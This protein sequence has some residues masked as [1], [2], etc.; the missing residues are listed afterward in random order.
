ML[1]H[2]KHL[3]PRGQHSAEVVAL[4]VEV[5]EKHCHCKVR[6][7]D[8]T[9]G[10]PG[11]AIKA[12]ED[13]G[14]RRAVASRNQRGQMRGDQYS[15]VGQ[16][17]EKGKQKRLYVDRVVD[18]ALRCFFEIDALRK[19]CISR[20][21]S[22]IATNLH[23][24]AVRYKPPGAVSPQVRVCVCECVCARVCVCDSDK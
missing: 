12:I 6:T 21:I 9:N 23:N 7:G 24:T 3:Q 11:S 16:E 4:R 18:R 2:Q 1:K 17:A 20:L 5:F 10:E 19:S 22:L 15:R 13:A 8:A 14:K